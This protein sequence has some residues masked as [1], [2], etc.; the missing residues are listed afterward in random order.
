MPNDSVSEIEVPPLG[1]L[2]ERV[3]AGAHG[4]P[5]WSEN[6]TGVFED[7]V[8]AFL[9]THFKID[10]PKKVASTD[11][12][13]KLYAV[14]CENVVLQAMFERAMTSLLQKNKDVVQ[15]KFTQCHNTGT[16]RLIPA[17]DIVVEFLIRSFAAHA[18]GDKAK[19]VKTSVLCRKR[20]REFMTTR[21]GDEG[22]NQAVADLSEKLEGQY[23]ERTLLCAAFDKI[24]DLG[25]Y[26]ADASDRE[27]DL[28]LGLVTRK[29]IEGG[30]GDARQEA[31][32]G[33]GKS[34]SN[35]VAGQEGSQR[36]QS[37]S[38]DV[39]A[40]KCETHIK[41]SKADGKKPADAGGNGSDEENDKI[42]HELA[43]TFFSEVFD[44]PVNKEGKWSFDTVLTLESL[45]DKCK[46]EYVR[47]TYACELVRTVQQSGITDEEKL[48][49][50]VKHA[51]ID[52]FDAEKTD[53]EA[54]DTLTFA[55]AM[56]Q[57]S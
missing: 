16:N 24:V 8:D 22:F 23:K 31:A 44:D 14:I 45:A 1:K 47:L 34:S 35:N 56:L 53:T 41:R 46:G 48:N 43:R 15:K 3:K 20:C 2:N 26:T 42:L 13:N 51:L 49:D 9:L 37:A 38:G 11:N 32:G 12:D 7:R 50:A 39:S 4:L 6:D 36:E 54:H 21:K 57:F 18:T 10:K 19:L 30:S 5:A 27:I 52:I 29:P 55:I 17:I 40:K 28:V 33:D 25:L